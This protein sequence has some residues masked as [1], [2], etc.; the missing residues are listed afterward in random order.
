MH[1][2]SLPG[3]FLVSNQL[4]QQVA[5]YNSS[6][7]ITLGQLFSHFDNFP[8]QGYFEYLQLSDCTI[9]IVDSLKNTSVPSQWVYLLMNVVTQ[10]FCISGVHQLSAF[11]TSVTLNMVLTVRK[12]VSVL[13]SV[14][15]FRNPFSISNA[16]GAVLVV[17]G[18]LWYSMQ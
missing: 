3:F 5:E 6:R 7:L 14:V 12:F 13:I 8:L 15:V 9:T 2:L 1:I 17:G 10:S 16:M 11:S 4:A 18:T